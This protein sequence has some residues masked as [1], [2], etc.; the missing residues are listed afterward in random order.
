MTTSFKVTNTSV[1]SDDQSLNHDIFVRR[2][3]RDQFGHPTFGEE[4]ILAPGESTPGHLY[5]Y[6]GV[7]FIVFEAKRLK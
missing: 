5:V 6:E 1:P 7:E 4:Y 3:H 2:V